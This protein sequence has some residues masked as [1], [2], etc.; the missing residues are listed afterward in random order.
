MREILNSRKRT[1]AYALIAIFMGIFNACHRNAAHGHSAAEHH[2]HRQSFE[3]LV[4][5]FEDPARDQWQKPEA[6][7]A[8]IAAHLQKQKLTAPVVADLGAGTGYF[9]FRL[10]DKGYSVKALD[11]G[12]KFIA[13]LKERA[14]KHP[15]SSQIEI[16]KVTPESANLKDGEVDVIL[17]VDVYHHIDN[18]TEYFRKL[19]SSLR[20]PQPLLMI[21][22]FKDGDIA[23]GPPAHIKVPTATIVA[24]L[25]A[26][27]YKVTT[28]AKT[29]PYQ[30]I[31]FATP[32]K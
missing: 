30:N 26:A 4:K 6:V 15:R 20:G 21:I 1:V 27:G 13:Y 22:D 31:F 28:D 18:R 19:K 10:L 5:R 23:V 29:L 7:I 17:S 2:M 24:E 8:L 32:Q 16:R 25:T 12:D 11:L 9:S 3:E 14:A